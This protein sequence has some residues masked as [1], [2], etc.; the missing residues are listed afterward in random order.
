VL[1]RDRE[2][3]RGKEL[4]LESQWV[5]KVEDRRREV[6]L[7]SLPLVSVAWIGGFALR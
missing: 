5:G 6:I 2:G 3:G 1:R 7:L 4:D